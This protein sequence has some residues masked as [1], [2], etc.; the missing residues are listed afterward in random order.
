VQKHLIDPQLVREVCL[1][2]ENKEVPLESEEVRRRRQL[3]EEGS[4]LMH[5]ALKRFTPDLDEAFKSKDFKQGQ[6]L[7]GE[8]DPSSIAPLARLFRSVEL[9]PVKLPQL[10]SPVEEWHAAVRGVVEKRR[11]LLSHYASN[12]PEPDVQ[13]ARV[14]CFNPVESLSD[15]AAA[16]CSHGIVDDDNVPAWDLWVNYSEGTLFSVV[17]G[18]FVALIEAGIDSNPEQCIYWKR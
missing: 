1:W 8:G 16:Y 7:V 9:K 6:L 14:L 10:G 11:E 2:A 15:G 12:R 13:L 17:P 4:L 5:R 3:I 18:S